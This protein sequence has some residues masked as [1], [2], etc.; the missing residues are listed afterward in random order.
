MRDFFRSASGMLRDGGEV[1]VSHKTT[2]PFSKW[3]I[4]ELAIESSLS[5]ILCPEFKIEDYPAYNNKKGD[6][7]KCDEPFPL[8][9]S[10]TFIFGFHPDGKEKSGGMSC[11]ESSGKRSRPLQ[12]IR[13]Q[14]QNLENS[15]YSRYPHANSTTSSFLN[16]QRKKPKIVDDYFNSIREDFERAGHW[17]GCSIHESPRFDIPKHSQTRLIG[18]PLVSD[19]PGRNFR[20]YDDCSNNANNTLKRF[21]NNVGY[22]VGESLISYERYMAEA[23]GRTLNSY[24]YLI[25]QLDRFRRLGLD[26]SYLRL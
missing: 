2:G 16:R 23:P 18:L 9:K 17:V 7:W 13:F 15:L 8:G 1:H 19:F 6:G 22:P 21:E 20:I 4:K 3:N 24:I 11:N 10:S 25:D 5:F 26:S 14:E 12:E